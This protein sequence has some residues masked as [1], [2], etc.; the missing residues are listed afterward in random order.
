MYH[1][2]V[3]YLSYVNAML[4]E[5]RKGNICFA[6]AL[7]GS[8]DKVNSYNIY[9]E[10]F[11]KKREPVFFEA[12][13]I[14]IFRSRVKKQPDNGVAHYLLGQVYEVYGYFGEALKSYSRSGELMGK[15]ESITKKIDQIKIKISKNQES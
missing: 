9:V 7:Y 4:P 3:K 5:F 14:A 1:N 2:A 12:E 8:G 10:V 6:V 13:T 11:K 15:R